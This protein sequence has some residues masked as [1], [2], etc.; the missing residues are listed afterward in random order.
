MNK[1]ITKL[2]STLLLTTMLAYTTPILAFTKEETVY[3]KINEKG[4]NYKTIVSTHLRNEEG[5][6]I[7]ND[8]TDL[9]NI[10]NTNGDEEFKL[11]GE[12]II[13]NANGSDIYYQGETE[14][15][16]PVEGNIKYELNGEELE[17]CDIVGK[18]GKV[19]I[20]IEYKNKDAHEVT[21]NG[22][23]QTMYT[24]FT[25]IC[26]SYFENS[27]NKNIEA[28]NAKVINDGTKTMIVGITM[29]G[30]E[31]S[32]NISNKKIEIPSKVEITMETSKFEQ[33]NIITFVTP[34]ILD[35]SISF[36][37]LNN[38]YKKV[39][40][41]R[42]ASK[43][44]EDGANALKEGT[45]ELSEKSQEF[46]DGMKA[47]EAGT[48]KLNKGAQDLDKGATDVNNGATKLS[49]GATDLNNG[50]K[51]LNT[52]AKNLNAGA[53]QLSS[54]TEELQKG[55]K[56][57]KDKA[58]QTLTQSSKTLAAGIDKIMEG[59]DT[60]T[61]TIKEVVIKNGNNTLKQN[62]TPAVAEGTKKIAVGTVQEVLKD[63]GV[64]LT[65]V[66]IKEIMS[67]IDTSVLEKSIDTAIDTASKQEQA[68][69]DAINNNEKGVKAG[70]NTLKAQAETSIEAGI[71]ELGTGFDAISNG[72]KSLNDG[73]T[74]LEAGTKG[75]YAGTGE[76][77]NGSNELANGAKELNNGTTAL[78]TGSKQIKQGLNTLKES[79]TILT[80][81]SN[82]LTEGATTINK[83]SI[84]LAKGITTFNKEA[85]NK[86]CEFVNS[87]VKEIALR[88][89]KLQELSEEYKNFS[90]ANE[91]TAKE[92]KFILISDSVKEK[93]EKEEN[94]KE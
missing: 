52:G 8:L 19:K 34:K 17:A 51:E 45:T 42:E 59:K 43:Q 74:K 21:I 35:E 50:V 7:L 27:Q 18:S 55:V 30:V 93:E 85:I 60:E 29:P 58:V 80:N 69:I 71:K 9:I 14:K 31:E 84:E 53:K 48:N 79:T 65:D 16:L 75:L 32:L 33:N 41:I 28:K 62:L 83:G 67:K 81:G 86:I 91:N 25:A 89:E 88:A 90:K 63:Y 6:Q 73:A 47:L 3:S 40:E 4:E 15:E 20:T 37:E 77:L 76:L 38:L 12:N 5:E 78:S 72:A 26:M 70:L 2:T 22:K 57:G 49:K 94:E 54:G 24:P 64:T 1:K 61:N 87:D 44:I 66:Q 36:D 23:K 56:A 46:N 92:V 10:E 13:W 82:A 39:D 68:G 11:D